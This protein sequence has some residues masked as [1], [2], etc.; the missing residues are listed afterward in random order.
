MAKPRRAAV[1]P[2]ATFDT[3]HDY[4]CLCCG[5]TYESPVGHFYK[6]Q[7]S[8][9][10]VQNSQ[11]VPICKQCVEDLFTD[12]ERRHKTKTACMILCHYMDVP[13]YHAVYNSIIENNNTFGIG[14]YMRMIQMRQYTKQDFSQTILT[15]EL[16]K[17]DIDVQTEREDKW[18]AS[19]KQ[20]QKTVLEICGYD[21]FDGYP[22]EDRRFLYGELIKYFDDDIT[23]DPFKLSQVLQIVIN[24]NQIRRYDIQLARLNP[25]TNS[26]DIKNIMTAKTNV[27][28]ANDKIAKENE[29]SVRN[30]SNK[31]VGKS[32]LGWLM[33][34]M[35]SVNIPDAEVN[36]YDQLHSTGTQWAAEMSMKAIK[37]NTFFDDAEQEQVFNTQRD[38][39][40]KL[41]AQVDDLQEENRLL[42]AGGST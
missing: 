28:T 19:D 6:S 1:D 5:R 39:I 37:Q 11:F 21:P 38:L 30:R 15:H 3:S 23:E 13:F 8:K 9:L 22:S 42:K 2:D 31:E 24:N 36:Y 29:I 35:R 40:A 34:R 7:W 14:M 41:Q 27:V 10:Y 12:L 20:N 26:E 18:S 4:R 25:I 32:T 33:K 16:S 17:T